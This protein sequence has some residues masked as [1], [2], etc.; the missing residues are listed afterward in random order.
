[1]SLARPENS[2]RNGGFED[3]TT[4]WSFEAAGEAKSEVAVVD[5]AAAGAKAALLTNS[6]GYAAGVCGSLW[7]GVAVKP[8]TRYVMS[9]RVKTTNARAC[10]MGGGEKWDKRQPLPANTD[11]W[12]TSRFEI[13]TDAAGV[14]FLRFNTDD[15]TEA[16]LIDD[17]QLVEADRLPPEPKPNR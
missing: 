5:D 12:E 13:T 6:S 10:W 14:W 15:V 7:T 9:A 11:G 1:M 16:L 17:V 2:V 8:N 4:G 3:G